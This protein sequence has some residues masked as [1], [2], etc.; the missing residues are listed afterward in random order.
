LWQVSS[1]EDRGLLWQLVS[2]VA[3]LNGHAAVDTGSQTDV[4]RYQ[5]IVPLGAAIYSCLFV[6]LLIVVLFVSTLL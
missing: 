6:C 1:T 3:A 4:T 2:E 5:A